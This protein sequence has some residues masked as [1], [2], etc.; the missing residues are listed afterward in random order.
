MLLCLAVIF[1]AVFSP[2]LV[3]LENVPCLISF[4]RLSGEQAQLFGVWRPQ[5]DLLSAA[6]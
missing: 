3:D 1:L 2:V 6:N 5:V 4:P